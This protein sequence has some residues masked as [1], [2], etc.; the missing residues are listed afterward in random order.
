MT[1]VMLTDFMFQSTE[2]FINQKERKRAVGKLR[3]KVR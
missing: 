2:S 1:I 3:R